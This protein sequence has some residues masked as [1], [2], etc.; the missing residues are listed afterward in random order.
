MEAPWIMTQDWLDVLFLHWPVEPDALRPHIPDGLELDTYEGQAWIGVVPFDARNTRPRFLPPVPGVRRYLELNVRTYVVRGEMKGVY[1]FSLD[2]DSRLA[3]STAEILLPYRY[4]HM[5]L[6]R[7]EN[8]LRF[9]SRRQHPGT[10]PE[11]FDAAFAISPEP[12]EETPLELWLTE[13]YSL[14]TKPAGKLLRVDIFHSPWKLRKASA[15][16][17]ANSMGSF[18]RRD[19]RSGQPLVHYGGDKHV[20]FWP[21]VRE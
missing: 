17:R 21:P 5:G 4:A 3:V 18:V 19:W 13:R 12:A 10:F 15:V 8:G 7:A 9:W 11:A 1:F 14:W 6:R 2:A 16:I 20:H